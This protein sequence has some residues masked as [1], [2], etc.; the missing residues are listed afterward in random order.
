MYFDETKI[1]QRNLGQLKKIKINLSNYLNEIK[2]LK[3]I[4]RAQ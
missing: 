2:T 3:T 1:M 4:N